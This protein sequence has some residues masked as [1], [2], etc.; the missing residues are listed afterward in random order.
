MI[1]IY[2]HRIEGERDPLSVVSE[3]EVW[4]KLMRMDGKCQ[5]PEG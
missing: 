4:A 1:N 3:N 2:L 5:A